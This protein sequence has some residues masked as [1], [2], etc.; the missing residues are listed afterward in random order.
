MTG[1]SIDLQN[2]R[3]LVDPGA[4][5]HHVDTATQ[6]YGLA[7]PVGINSTTGIAG[8]TLGGGFGWLTRKYGL[9][10]DNLLSA[11]VVTADGRRR[12]TSESENGDLFW[13]I[14]GGGGNFGVV[15]RFEFK[16]HVVGPKVVA[17]L[18]VFPFEQAKHVLTRYTEFVES[19]PA[20]LNVWVILRRAPPLPFLPATVHGHEVVAVAVFYSGDLDRADTA[21]E[22]LRQLGTAHWEHIDTQPYVTWQQAF[23][24]LLTAGARNYWKSHNFTRLSDDAI[25]CMIRFAGRLP[26]SQCE[27]FVGLVAG[28][29]NQVLP[30]ATAYFHRDAR[31]VMNVHARW[32]ARDD[33]ETCID[34]A[35][36]FFNASAPFAS[37]G[38]YVNFMTAE[39]SS[40]VAQAYGANYERLVRLKQKFDPNNIFHWNQNIPP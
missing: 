12:H 19:A 23:D 18:I 33:D 29:A 1:V 14:R 36:A 22:P 10:I 28:T 16:L 8:L 32:N 25:D 6:A 5:L 7:T 38:A 34:W 39:E 24:P 13:A 35:R 15:T 20:D 4:T 31:F 40:R 37:E 30:D 26:S 17:G 21:I 3:A 2:R 11:E 9:T 27:I